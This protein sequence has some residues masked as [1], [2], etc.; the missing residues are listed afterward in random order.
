M[1][2]IDILTEYVVKARQQD[3]DAFA[4]VFD[5]TKDYVYSLACSMIENTAEAQDVVQEVYLKVWLHLEHLREERSFLRWLHSI[6]FN[7]CQDHLRQHVQEHRLLQSVGGDVLSKTCTFD[8]WFQKSW[9]QE[10]VRAMIDALPADQRDA[11]HLY[12]FQNRT[13]GEIAVIRNCSINT[14]KSR[15]Y[16]A[17][18]TLQKL[19]EAEERKTGRMHLPPAVLA[20]TSVMMLPVL[21]NTLPAA[22]AMRILAA[23]FAAAGSIPGDIHI[24]GAD[25]PGTADSL[26]KRWFSAVRD[27]HWILHLR[28]SS[29]LPLLLSA[30]I[31]CMCLVTGGYALGQRLRTSGNAADTD[32]SHAGISAAEDIQ[33]EVDDLPEVQARQTVGVP[34]IIA[35]GNCGEHAVF[36]LTEDGTLSV[37]GSGSVGATREWDYHGLLNGED[38][39][40]FQ[41][42]PLAPYKDTVRQLIIGEGITE[43]GYA[44]MYGIKSLEHVSLPESCTVIRNGAFWGCESL[45]EFV[46]PS[47][48]Q[49]IADCVLKQCYAL[50]RIVVSEAAKELCGEAFSQCHSLEEII[51][52]GD[53]LHTIW[54]GAF[55]DTYSLQQLHLPPHVSR[56]TTYAFTKI[57]CTVLDLSA[58]TEVVMEQD[59][60]ESCPNLQTLILPDSMEIIPESLVTDCNCLTSVVI[61]ENTKTIGSR[62]FGTAPLTE[63][64]I[65]ASVICIEPGAF[66]GLTQLAAIHV[67]DGNR[68][69]SDIN[70]VLYSN[71]NTRIHTYPRNRSESAYLLPESVRIIG[72]FAFSGNRHLTT[73]IA[74]D[75]ITVL[76]QYAFYN[77]PNF[78]KLYLQGSLPLSRDDRA[79]QNCPKLTTVP[80]SE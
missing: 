43:I 52:C 10:T 80:W 79:V 2:D 68:V 4:K 26:R 25:A 54:S 74:P 53:D 41:L 12:Y 38:Q 13:V 72:K 1:I 18:N 55:C 48:V 44:A 73:V 14:V 39:S 15:L 11:V 5:L 19:I 70:G 75:D 51:F 63:I 45:T 58:L 9:R 65:P 78:S 31:V 64:T 6:T 32:P 23:V 76:E 71:N 40:I 34:R 47:G 60:F 36:T 30:V 77:L 67:E 37:T 3:A 49:M 8:E 56:L 66:N 35:E 27:R 17:R 29:L 69:Y 50:K 24:V 33:A 20:L 62:A 28:S 46:F 22:D 57:G 59:V 16:Y 42:E 21:Q 61:G 7:I